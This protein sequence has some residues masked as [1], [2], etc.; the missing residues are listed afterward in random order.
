ML[1]VFEVVC[2]FCSKVFL[3]NGR[4][5]KVMEGKVCI[6]FGEVKVVIKVVFVIKVGEV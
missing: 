1:F 5:N 2:N 4:F 6:K 3:L